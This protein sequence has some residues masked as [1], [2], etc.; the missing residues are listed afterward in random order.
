[1]PQRTV[2]GARLI[3][4]SCRQIEVEI[5]HRQ[6]PNLL[7]RAPFEPPDLLEAHSLKAVVCPY[8]GWFVIHHRSLLDKLN[9][10]TQ[11]ED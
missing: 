10:L 1:M 6:N 9:Q 3:I 8:H 4:M 11:T 5:F 2:T 7:K